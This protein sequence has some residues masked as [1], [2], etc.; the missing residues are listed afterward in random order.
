MGFW[1][2][3]VR[4]LGTVTD[5]ITMPINEASNLLGGPTIPSARQAI[6]ADPKLQDGKPAMGTVAG[7]PAGGV[8]SRTPPTNLTCSMEAGKSKPTFNTEAS[9]WYC[10]SGND[11]D[12]RNANLRAGGTPG[13]PSLQ[14]ITSEGFNNPAQAGFGARP[15]IG[16]NNPTPNPTNAWTGGGTQHQPPPG[17]GYSPNSGPQSNWQSRPNDGVTPP[18]SRPLANPYPNAPQ[19]DD[20][21]SRNPQY[22][23][24]GSTDA[25][26][27]TVLGGDANSQS[28]AT[29]Y[30][31]LNDSAE[32][33][34]T[35]AAAAVA[36]VSNVPA[37]DNQSLLMIG[38]AVV[39]AAVLLA[40]K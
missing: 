24:A 39:L 33:V 37:M 10:G 11:A 25:A 15:G 1:N 17:A 5:A 40:K 9:S 27:K 30:P 28:I 4:T 34:K 18:G 31:G 13:R 20:P 14:P 2:Q 26:T 6:D 36:D 7:A 29:G 23:L 12:R 35:A 3:I 38:G 19:S 16:G 22:N 21:G 32:A 8:N